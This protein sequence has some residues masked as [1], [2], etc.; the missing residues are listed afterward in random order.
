LLHVIGAMSKLRNNPIIKVISS[1]CW[2]VLAVTFI[3]IIAGSFSHGHF[4]TAYVFN[5]NIIVGAVIIAVG[6]MLYVKPTYLGI[7]RGIVDHSNYGSKFVEKRDEKERNA[8]EILM[9]GITIIIIAGLIQ[10]FESWI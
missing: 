5:S 8:N 9:I 7:E 10:L 3:S 2:I 1:A 6:I 4:T